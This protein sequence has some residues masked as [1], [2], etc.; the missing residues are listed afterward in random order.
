MAFGGSGWILQRLQVHSSFLEPW[1][2]IGHGQRRV[3][4]FSQSGECSFFSPDR[5]RK[6]KSKV[7]YWHFFPTLVARG[8]GQAS[9]SAPLVG[10]SYFRIAELFRGAG[11]RNPPTDIFVIVPFSPS[12]I[13][14]A[15]AT[16]LNFYCYEQFLRMFIAYHQTHRP[17]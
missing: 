12:L 6:I 3:H 1:A 17:L 8:Q 10:I 15:V 16:G 14:A 4:S 5:P 2:R 13:K 7:E 11:N 9:L